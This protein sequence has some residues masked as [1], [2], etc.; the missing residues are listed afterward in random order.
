MPLGTQFSLSVELAK[1]LPV[2]DAVSYTAESLVQLVRSLKASGSDFLVEEDLATIFG[3]GK[4]DQGLEGQFHAAAKIHSISPLYGGSEIVLSTGPSPT[5]SRALKDRY[6]MSCIIQLSLLAWTHDE[7]SLA[8]TLVDCMRIR[9]EKQTPGAAPEPAYNDILKTLQVCSSQTSQFHWDMAI[10]H[11]KSKLKNSLH[12]F[13]H[14]GLRPNQCSPAMFLPTK[15]LL[16]AMDY[17]Y[18][19]QS[20]PEDRFILMNRPRGLVPLIVWAHSIL[21]LSVLVEGSPDGNVA[22]GDCRRPQVVISWNNKDKDGDL[23]WYTFKVDDYFPQAIYLSDG[24]QEVLLESDTTQDRT[25]KIDGQERHRL[26]GFGTACLHRRFCKFR[27]QMRILYIPRPP[28][29]PY[30]M[31]SAFLADC[32]ARY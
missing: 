1:I 3:R 31:P 10:Q 8:A 17:L 4:I 18:L 13:E 29:L 7:K 26:K 25:L 23:D 14:S 32:D 19:V 27:R 22:F 11:V 15:I 6:Y 30:L 5:V 20:L 28:I 21:G 16:G 24:E 9:Y 12:F 2:R